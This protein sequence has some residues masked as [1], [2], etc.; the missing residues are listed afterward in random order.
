[1]PPAP[2][3][4]RLNGARHRQPKRNVT[5]NARWM[6]LSH[7]EVGFQSTLQ[8]GIAVQSLGCYIMIYLLQRLIIF[9][10]LLDRNIAW[11]TCPDALELINRSI[12]LYRYH[13]NTYFNYMNRSFLL[14]H[15]LHDITP[16]EETR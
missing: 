8:T 13:L 3:R 15:L 7:A 14:D 12:G 4:R 11:P 10:T 16:L 6:H 9:R 5:S 1:M 2:K